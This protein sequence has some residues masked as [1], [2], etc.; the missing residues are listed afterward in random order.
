MNEIRQLCTTSALP[1]K[2]LDEILALFQACPPQYRLPSLSLICQSISCMSIEQLDVSVLNHQLFFVIRQSSEHLLQSWLTNG[3]LNGHEYRAIFYIYQLFK[4]VSEWLI[5]QDHMIVDMKAKELT[6]RVMKSLFLDES[7]LK[8]LC[9]VIQQLVRYENDEQRSTV[10]S[11]LFDGDDNPVSPDDVHLQTHVSDIQAEQTDIIDVLFRCVNSLVILYTHP[12][13]LNSSIVDKNLT[14]CVI[15][16]L[17]SSLFLQ[18]ATDF[19]RQNITNDQINIQSI[20]LLF[21]CLDYCILSA[22]TISTLRLIPSIREIFQTWSTIPRMDISPLIIRLIRFINQ[23]TIADKEAIIRENLCSF[24]LPSFELLCQTSNLTDEIASILITLC[25][26]NLGRKHLRQLGFIRHILHGTKRYVQLWRPLALLL[27]QQD[28]QETSF[29]NRLIHLLTQRTITLFQSLTATSNDTSFDS[30]SPSS[31]VQLTEVTIEWLLLLRTSFLTFSSIVD[32]LI[33]TKRKVNFINVLI[34]TILSVQQDEDTLPKLIDVMI[35][36]LWTFVFST[37]TTISETLPKHLDLCQ[38]LK[39]NNAE[40]LPSIRL[41][42]Q[43]ILSTLEFN[44]KTLNRSSISTNI[45]ICMIYADE[46]HRDLCVILRDRLQMEQQYS[47]ELL[48]TSTC[49][50]IESLIQLLNRSSLALFCASTQMKSDNL[51]HFIHHYLSHQSYKTPLL[52]I[53]TEQDCELDGNW[54]ENIS[55][56]DKQSMLKQI[57]RYLNQN[58][59]SHLPL[60]DI[61]NESYRRVSNFHDIHNQSGNYTQRPVTYWTADDVTQW[62]EATPGNF[63]TLRP[64]VKRLNGPALVHLAEILSIEPASMYHSLNSELIQ[65]TGSNVPLTDYVSLRSELQRLLVEKLPEN[66]PDADVKAKPK[67]RRWKHSRFCTII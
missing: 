25:S 41:T 22:I 48:L 30:T 9:R 66:I 51:S 20:F 4:L 26:I 57:R 55:I 49:Q 19:L 18:L 62:C 52:A 60:T 46:A 13:L 16:C 7:F 6:K 11:P 8:T 34:D 17:H 3:S 37:T 44:S 10:T 31:K 38:W 47:V 28:L 67:K 33:S 43:G 35:E 36:F 64:L 23:L 56:V 65:R 53:L 27:I 54:L 50:S 58:D 5:E 39:S 15:H 59:E 2:H 12:I 14:P 21:T 32:G 63:E 29:L 42:S 45:L 61:P 24:F 40:S 1:S